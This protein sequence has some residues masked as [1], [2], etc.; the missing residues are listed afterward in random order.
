MIGI[1]Y[2]LHQKIRNC[3]INHNMVI[4]YNHLTDYV[5]IHNIDDLYMRIGVI[6]HAEYEYDMQ[7]G[8]MSKVKVIN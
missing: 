2:V 6:D 5:Q 3:I 4:D 1:F 7:L 8:Q